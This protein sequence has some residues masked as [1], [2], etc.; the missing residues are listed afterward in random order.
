[1]RI[2]GNRRTISGLASFGAMA[3]LA[4]CIPSVAPPMAPSPP[5]QPDRSYPDYRQDV[6]TSPSPPPAWETNPVAPNARTIA[7]RT[8]TVEPGDT[9]RRIAIKTGGGEL[10]IAQANGLAEPYVIRAGQRL[11]I[12]GGRYHEI[13]RLEEHT[14][15]LQSLM[16]ISYA[17]FCLTKTTTK[18]IK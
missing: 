8:Y 7:T 9:L 14:S 4:G 5:P 12:P 15:E 6:T 18:R 1:M 3:A 16:R 17:G 10:A 11:T 2:A 13:T